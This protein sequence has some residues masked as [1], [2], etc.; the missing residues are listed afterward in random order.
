MNAF[1]MNNVK[2]TC[3]KNINFDFSEIDIKMHC[4]NLQLGI[5][6]KRKDHN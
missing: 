4:D 3:R 6:P 1:M 2:Y 5:F